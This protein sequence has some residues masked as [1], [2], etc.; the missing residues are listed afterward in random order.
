MSLIQFVD[1]ADSTRIG[2][3]GLE[4]YKDISHV[5][6]GITTLAVVIGAL[7]AKAAG[8][9]KFVP[10]RDSN[11]TRLLK[12]SLGGSCHNYMLCCIGPSFNNYDETLST[13]RF[14]DRVRGISNNAVTSGKGV[15][16]YEKTEKK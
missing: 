14:A 16:E 3:P 7:R 2:K 5:D 15:E 10:Y 9:N 11:V 4:I 1:L 6:K 12:N 13:L 8:K